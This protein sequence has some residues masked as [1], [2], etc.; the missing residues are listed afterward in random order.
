M[1]VASA[2]GSPAAAYNLAH[3]WLRTANWVLVAVGMGICTGLLGLRVYTK[4]RIMRRFWWDDAMA[5]IALLILYYRLLNMITVWKYVIVLFTFII[6]GYTIALTLALIFACHPIAKNWDASIKT[7]YCVNRVG[8]Y[9]AT[10][11]TNTASDVVLII[12]PIPVVLGLRL[13]LVQKLGIA[14]MFGMGCL[15]IITSILRLATLLPLVSSPD[16]TYKLGLE[17]TFV[18]I[19]ANFIIICGSLPY[20][21][22]FLRFHAP[23][24][25]G[26]SR[27][28]SSQSRPQPISCQE[29]PAYKRRKSGL[30]QLQD[31][32]EQALSRPEEAHCSSCLGGSGSGSGSG[33]RDLRRLI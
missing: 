28:S 15:T 17:V 6:V 3:P 8:L 19:E 32:I 2:A 5:K 13:P 26:D 11:I 25:I 20:L 4:I 24:W 31:D 22:Q 12:I 9:L 23:R 33:E 21:R 16:Q 27:G 29:M 14:C 30:S 10:A 7:G 1:E 18:V